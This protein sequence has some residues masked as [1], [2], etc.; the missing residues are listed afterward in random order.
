[1]EH[2]SVAIAVVGYLIGDLV[3]T[4]RLIADLAI[5]ITCSILRLGLRARGQRQSSTMDA[6]LHAATEVGLG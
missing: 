2:E 5:L 3:H 1:M 6:L 4:D